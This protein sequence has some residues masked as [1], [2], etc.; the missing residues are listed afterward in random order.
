MREDYRSIAGLGMG[1]WGAIKLMDELSVESAP[2]KGTTVT[3]KKW[4][5]QLTSDYPSGCAVAPSVGGGA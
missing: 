1:I 5:E 2:G 4:I 3:M